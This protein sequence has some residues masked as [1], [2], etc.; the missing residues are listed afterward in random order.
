MSSIKND[1]RNFPPESESG[2]ENSSNK[3]SSSTNGIEIIFT[4]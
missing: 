1:P 4:D 2:R 3:Q